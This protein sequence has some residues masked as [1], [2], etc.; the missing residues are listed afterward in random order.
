[1]GKEPR[2]PSQKWQGHPNLRR[3][4]HSPN[5]WQGRLQKAIARCFHTHGPEVSAAVIYDWTQ[6]WPDGRRFYWSTKRILRELCE[7][8]GR[9]STRGRPHIWRLKSQ[10]SVANAVASEEIT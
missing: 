3:R 6:T 4:P 8:I 9:A 10:H 5:A 2:T 1:M 7:P